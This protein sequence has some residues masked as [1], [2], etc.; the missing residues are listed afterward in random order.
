MYLNQDNMLNNNQENSNQINE[1]INIA[2]TITPQE[3]KSKLDSSEYVIID[4]RTPEEYNSGHIKGAT[5]INF[6]DNN[7]KEELNQ[8]DKTKKY[9][10]YCRSGARSSRALNIA[11]E[12]KFKEIY[13]LQGGILAWTSN[14]YKIVK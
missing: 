4:V 3:F 7:F 11:K 9:I 1:N 13:D 5:N 6:Y 14:N 8:L 10:I 12:L 2:K